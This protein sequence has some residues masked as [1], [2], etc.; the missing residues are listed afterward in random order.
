MDHTSGDVEEKEEYLRGVQETRRYKALQR[1]GTI[2]RIYDKAALSS[3]IV[4]ITVFTENRGERT[5]NIR[6]TA[7]YV[8]QDG[9]WRLAAWH[10]T[11]LAE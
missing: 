6:Y 2:F 10:N 4:H 3:G 1:E 11:R 9:G 7:A 8:V 5:L